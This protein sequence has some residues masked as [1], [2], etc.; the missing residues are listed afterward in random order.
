VE[1]NIMPAKKKIKK[2][3]VTLSS[4][5]RDYVDII[6]N[7]DNLP[8]QK[9][10]NKLMMK[11]DA[12]KADRKFL[13]MLLADAGKG[14]EN[15]DKPATPVSPYKIAKEIKNYRELQGFVERFAG[16]MHEKEIAKLIL[17][18]VQTKVGFNRWKILE[19]DNLPYVWT[20]LSAIDKNPRQAVGVY[21]IYKKNPT[22]EVRNPLR[23]FE[24]RTSYV[25]PTSVISFQADLT[26][27]KKL[28]NVARTGNY[29]TGVGSSEREFDS[30]KWNETLKAK[31]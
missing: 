11:P 4:F 28:L 26:R 20:L 16:G 19:N 30:W 9:K 3:K 10:I 21:E 14:M 17:D 7:R 1:K 23:K 31:K 8:K 18:H 22:S 12:T 13:A 27:W 6:K 29:R 5:G 24:V 15:F 2:E 25:V